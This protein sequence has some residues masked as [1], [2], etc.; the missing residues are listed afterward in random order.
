[1]MGQQRKRREEINIKALTT[2]KMWRQPPM[3][4]R[5]KL[6]MDAMSAALQLRQSQKIGIWSPLS[7]YDLAESLGVE[8]RFQ[9][10]SS[11]EGIYSKKNPGP[12]IIISS[13]RPTG[14]Q[15]Y[16]CGHELGHHV[17]KHGSRIDQ[18]IN[19]Q[20]THG[21]FNPEEFLAD[22]FAGFLLMPKS[23]INKAFAD[24]GWNP[25]S[26]TAQQLYTIAGLFGVGY[27]TLIQHLSQT[28]KLMPDTLAKS[29]SKI[30]PKQI[31]SIYLGQDFSED[32]IIVDAHWSGRAIDIQVGDYIQLPINTFSEGDCVRFQEKNG[33]TVLF[34]GAIPGLGRFDQPDTGW[35]A[36]VR[37]SR[38]GYVGRNVYRYW[39]DT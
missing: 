25:S 28:L 1:M 24:R 15:A 22:C 12:L 3:A 35:S 38:R 23:A 32:L 19:S 30:S 4:Q 29:L 6:A 36:F 33:Q 10:Y 7:P 27:T 20:P 37:V 31:R 17:F 14:R 16:T 13:L 5:T 26:C 18:L 34:C 39:E 21:Y 2:K 8:V 9:D 11:M